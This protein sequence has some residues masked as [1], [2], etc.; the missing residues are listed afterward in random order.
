MSKKFSEFRKEIDEAALIPQT[1]KDAGKKVLDAGKAASSYVAQKTAGV[2]QKIKSIYDKVPSDSNKIMNM[3]Q[4]F[5]HY[6][7]KKDDEEPEEKKDVPQPEN[8]KS[9]QTP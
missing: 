8:K 3:D 5:A 7:K 1:V 4:F 6:G 2:R 9:G